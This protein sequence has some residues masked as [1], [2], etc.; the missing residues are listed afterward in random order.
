M[1]SSLVD[2]T[3][4]RVLSRRLHRNRQ[5]HHSA[6]VSAGLSSPGA[7]CGLTVVGHNGK[8][9]GGYPRLGRE[10]YS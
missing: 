5:G 1:A 7:T 2:Q 9:W 10:A 8:R 6:R 3:P 4:L